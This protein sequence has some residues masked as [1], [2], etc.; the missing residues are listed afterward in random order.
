[1]QVNVKTAA[2]LLNVSEKM[3]TRWI[4][5]GRI[6]AQEVDGQYQIDREKLL[7]WATRERMNISTDEIQNENPEEETIPSL[8][9]A[10][11]TG[12]I[13]Y[14]VAGND[15]VAVLQSVVNLLP[16]PDD[17]NREFLF[18]VFL[19]RESVGSTGIGQGVAIPHARNPVVRHLSKPMIALCFLE[20]PVEYQ[21]IDGQAVHTLFAIVSSSTKAHLALIS[22]LM[23]V[24]QNPEF[25][26]LIDNKGSQEEILEMLGKIEDM[27]AS[28]LAANEKA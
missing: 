14:H 26:L 16:V 27:L 28:A 24:L 3:V 10:V 20:K 11:R 1:M 5:Q 15:K 8:V 2:R 9:D 25:R 4:T 17:V 6:S 19:A 13:H 18:Q 7:E 12:G 22:R 21:A 23:F